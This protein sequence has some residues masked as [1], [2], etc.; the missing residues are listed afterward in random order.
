MA[1]EEAKTCPPGPKA[2]ARAMGYIEEVQAGTHFRSALS[3]VG[4]LRR[5][6]INYA[7]CVR[8]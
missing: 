6:E 5:R 8:V 7:A 1:E 3:H 2:M 4:F